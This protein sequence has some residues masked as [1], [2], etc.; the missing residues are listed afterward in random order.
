[1]S[2]EDLVNQ[3]IAEYIPDINRS[4]IMYL[5]SNTIVLDAYNANPVSM[6][7]SI[8][9]FYRLKSSNKT[10][11][12]GGMLELGPQEELFHREIVALT[13]D[14]P[15]NNEVLLCGDEMLAVREENVKAKY[16]KY[17][18]QLEEYLKTIKFNNSAIL[19]KASRS[20]EFETLVEFIKED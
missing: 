8:E 1:M 4:E 14:L 17:K 10:M 3:A 9:S 19:L 13:R 6:K 20:Y 18:I 16:F 5:G 12:L 2:E 15:G 11:I 7:C